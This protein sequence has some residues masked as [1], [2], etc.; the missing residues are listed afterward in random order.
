MRFEF[1][2]HVET[3]LKQINENF[4]KT[5]IKFVNERIKQFDLLNYF[6]N[7]EMIDI[8]NDKINECFDYMSYSSHD[9]NQFDYFQFNKSIMIFRI[10]QTF[11]EKK[12][13]FISIRIIN[14]FKSFR[15]FI[16]FLT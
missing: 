12:I 15:Y 5:Q 7:N 9:S 3:K 2:T 13:D 8:N 4:D 10:D 16:L 14:N 11:I 6:N 1:V